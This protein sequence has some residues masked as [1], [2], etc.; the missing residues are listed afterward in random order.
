MVTILFDR[1]WRGPDPRGGFEMFPAGWRGSLDRARA[2]LAIASGVARAEE[3]DAF[4]AAAQE[5]APAAKAQAK[6]PAA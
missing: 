6:K 3:P 5:A 1:E 2:E 4:A